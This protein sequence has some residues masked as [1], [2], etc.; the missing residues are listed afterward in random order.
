V[1][2]FAIDKSLQIGG[3]LALIG[4]VL[5]L[6]AALL[7]EIPGIWKVRLVGFYCVAAVLAVALS[8]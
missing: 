7:L 3:A 5:V 6:A 4:L 8:R 1:L 2:V